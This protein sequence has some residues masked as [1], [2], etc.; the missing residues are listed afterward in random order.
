[1]SELTFVFCH[2]LAGWGEYDK[3]NEKMPYWG[4]RTGDLVKEFRSEGYRCSAA[5]VSPTGSAWDRACE[6][7]A[8]LA[9]VRTDY[10]RAH[11][12]EYRHERY[13]PDFTGRPLIPSWNEE[14][15]LVL[16]GHSFGGATVRVLTQ[17]LKDGDPAEREQTHPKDLSPLFAGGMENRVFAVVTLAAPT[18]GT[19]AYDMYRDPSFDAKHAGVPLK[20][21]IL[22][23]L[24]RH[25][26]KVKTDGRD[27]RDYA[28]YDMGIDRAMEINSRIETLPGTYYFSAACCSTLALADGTEYP[29][30]EI[31]DGLFV[32]GSALMGRYAGVTEK[33]FVIDES[34]RKNDGLVNTASARAPIGAPQ[35]QF[36]ESDIPQGIWN[37]LPDYKGDHGS[38]QGGFTIRHDPRLFYR[39]LLRIISSLYEG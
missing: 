18:N 31:T 39:N 37:I 24:M 35:K 7:Y 30:T 27:E 10:G 1:M 33:G 8:Q 36:D 29:D 32:R 26:T 15:K 9:G 12:L 25:S 23:A 22:A 14:T 21:E 28:N 17:L 34:W 5:S 11:S 4:R 19:T 3:K 38:F 13:G 6:L 20:Y 2:G 16:I